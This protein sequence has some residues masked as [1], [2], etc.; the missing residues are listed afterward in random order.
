M[1]MAPNWANIVAT[2]TLFLK[3]SQRLTQLIILVSAQAS[4]GYE[5]NNDIFI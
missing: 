4:S 1:P 3:S 2:F 5:I